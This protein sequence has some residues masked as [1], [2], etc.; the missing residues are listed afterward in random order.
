MENEQFF[1]SDLESETVQRRLVNNLA[2]QIVMRIARAMA[3]PE[4]FACAVR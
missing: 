3:S 2:D 1:A 4:S